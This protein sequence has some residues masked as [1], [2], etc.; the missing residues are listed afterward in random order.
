M[1]L[2]QKIKNKIFIT[3]CVFLFFILKTI[4]KQIHNFI[5]K[6]LLSSK[7]GKINAP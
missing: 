4:T 6:I 7:L 3:K 1:F 2:K 5:R